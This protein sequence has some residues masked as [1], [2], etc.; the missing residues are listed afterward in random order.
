MSKS[1]TA[2]IEAAIRYA[3]QAERF[4]E[5]LSSQHGE[6]A[7]EIGT[8]GVSECLCTVTIN[9]QSTRKDSTDSAGAPCCEYEITYVDVVIEDDNGVVAMPT[10]EKEIKMQFLLSRV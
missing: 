10:L 4:R 3:L 9:Y 1:D 8:N 7:I 5:E 2:A 6:L